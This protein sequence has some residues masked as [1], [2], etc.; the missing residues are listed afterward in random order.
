LRF[1]LPGSAAPAWID[2]RIQ[3]EIHVDK[4]AA[5]AGYIIGLAAAQGAPVRWSYVLAD[6]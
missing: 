4:A 2:C 3:L 6:G 5:P 1:R